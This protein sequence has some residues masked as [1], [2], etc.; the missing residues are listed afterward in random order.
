MRQEILSLWL[1]VG[2]RK[3]AFQELSLGRELESVAEKF[4]I[5]VMYHISIW[6][7]HSGD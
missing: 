4:R 1:K 5:T 2:W 6:K 7:I 3:K